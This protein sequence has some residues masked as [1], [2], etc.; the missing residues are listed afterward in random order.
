MPERKENSEHVAG[1]PLRKAVGAAK[2]AIGSAIGNDQLSQEGRVQR[3]QVETEQKAAE[4][5]R[6][7]AVEEERADIAGARSDNRARRR[8]LEHELAAEKQEETIERGESSASAAASERA[9]EQTMAAEHRRRA[10]ENAADAQERVARTRE[11]A[12]LDEAE[13]LRR[14]ARQAERAA[15]T[16]DPEGES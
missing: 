8:E 12:E 13:Q 3:V 1:G 5:A 10:E 6:E 15:D 9:H 11:V 7:A 2:E 16:V 14:Q 4:H